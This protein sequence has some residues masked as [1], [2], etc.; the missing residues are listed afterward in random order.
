MD[1]W[2]EKLI[3]KEKMKL[4]NRQHLMERIIDKESNGIYR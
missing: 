4:E 3:A 2:M 1:A